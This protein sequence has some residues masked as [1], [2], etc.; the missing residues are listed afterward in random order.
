MKQLKSPYRLLYVFVMTLICLNITGCGGS[1]SGDEP[2]EEPTEYEV[3]RGSLEALSSANKLF[4]YDSNTENLAVDLSPT[5]DYVVV[6]KNTGSSIQ[7]IKLLKS[8]TSWTSVRAVSEQ[9]DSEEK[10]DV[11]P[12]VSFFDYET[13]ASHRVQLQARLNK[14]NA[15]AKQQNKM[16]DGAVLASRMSS[17]W[18]HSNEK[19]GDLCNFYA[20]NPYLQ[21]GE[22]STLANSTIDNCKFVY[23]TEHAKFF[24]DQNV[25]GKFSPYAKQMEAWVKEEGGLAS[26][27]DKYSSVSLYKVLHEYFGDVADVDN[28]GKISILI[29]PQLTAW[30][31]RLLGLFAYEGMVPGFQ[32][33]DG[34]VFPEVRD[35][36]MIAPPFGETFSNKSKNQLITNL[37][38]ECQHAVNFSARAFHNNTFTGVDKQAYAE[39]LGFDE[40]CS[41]YAEAICRRLF[42]EAG[43]DTLYDYKTGGTGL[44]YTGNDQRFI[45]FES[46]DIFNS[47]YPFYNVSGGGDW[48]TYLNYSTMGLFMLYLSDRFSP[49]KVKELV[50]LDFQGN[51]L[52]ET[53]PNMLGVSSFEELERGWRIAMGN[54]VLK[55]EKGQNDIGVS[56]NYCFRD[57]LKLPLKRKNFNTSVELMYG[58]TATF[59]ITPTGSNSIG[60]Y[61]FFINSSSNNSKKLS[62]NIIRLQ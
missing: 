49:D 27:F 57:W 45:C 26:Y 60:N 3:A 2:W 17:S 25:R 35:F 22:I 40:G 54:E 51:R 7:Y 33:D 39:E 31:D 48:H 5:G 11:N 55:N 6:V 28:D 20:T 14:I 18:D 4:S 53:I 16:Q 43:F 44:E 61:R 46:L 42:G 62:V 37:L 59:R 41:V 13:E 24:V 56:R 8:N 21:F 52:H 36:I 10:S 12:T 50:Q 34:N 58:D 15:I 32:L 23:E 38:H 29:T 30:S 19:V 9:T 47:L 1:S